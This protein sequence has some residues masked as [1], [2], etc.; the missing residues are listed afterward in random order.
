[1]QQLRERVRGLRGPE[2]AKICAVEQMS[3]LTDH[4]ARTPRL[5]L[6]CQAPEIFQDNYGEI[7]EFLRSVPWDKTASEKCTSSKCNSFV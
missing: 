7:L 4:Y 3:A 2:A 5:H 6:S 1:M